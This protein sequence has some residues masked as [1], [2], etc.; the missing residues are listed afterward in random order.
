MAHGIMENDRI[1]V[2]D[3]QAWHGKANVFTEEM[4]GR[5]AQLE[6]APYRLDKFPSMDVNGIE[7]PDSYYLSR[8]DTREPIAGNLGADY[9]PIQPEEIADIVDQIVVNPGIGRV[10]S[11]GTV[12]GHQ[13]FWIDCEIDRQFRAGEDVNQPFISFSNNNTGRRKFLAGA[14]LH[15]VVCNNTLNLANREMKTSPRCVA[16]RHSRNASERLVHAKKTLSVVLATFDQFD[17][18][19]HAMIGKEMSAS[20]ISCFYDMVMPY[21]SKPMDEDDLDKYD[22]RYN[23]VHRIRQQ[24][25][26][27][28]HQESD[29]LSTT[30]NLWLALN[31]VTNWQQHDSSVHGSMNNQLKREASNRFG[32][33]YTKTNKAHD[34]AYAMLTA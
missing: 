23:K 10:T 33:N 16:I 4:S 30:S 24:W 19:M 27:T 15:R 18:E 29:K 7:I 13:D 2:K 25:L 11:C 12:N 1:L 9:C 22:R 8:N 14:H 3:E 34:I 21:P 6:V 20:D 5:A 32:A 28:L 26:G 31:S 17:A